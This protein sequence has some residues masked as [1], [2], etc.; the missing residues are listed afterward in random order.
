MP[1]Y[2]WWEIGTEL[3]TENHIITV[4]LSLMTGLHLS[5]RFDPLNS[6]LTVTTN[7]GDDKSELSVCLCWEV[8]WTLLK[9]SPVWPM[10]VCLERA[11]EMACSQH[12]EQHLRL[13][14]SLKQEGSTHLYR[15]PCFQVSSLTLLITMN[16]NLWSRE[17]K[18]EVENRSFW[19]RE[20]LSVSI[21][22]FRYLTSML[23]PQ[24]LQ[25][26]SF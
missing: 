9:Q 16:W 18:T 22:I 24:I 5:S 20:C 13:G 15:P 1:M 26:D 14:A 3:L 10:W 23:L 6:K 25:V 4:F 17:P 8:H 21:I 7:T 19:G 2:I 12:G 11:G